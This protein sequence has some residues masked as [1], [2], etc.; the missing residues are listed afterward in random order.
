MTDTTIITRCYQ[1]PMKTMSDPIVGE[2][3]YPAILDEP[4]I[5]A[6]SFT[7]GSLKDGTEF[8]VV[9]STREGWLAFDAR[10]P[11]QDAQ[12]GDPYPRR[13]PSEYPDV[14]F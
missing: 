4:E 11:N 9:G 5:D 6:G 10:F 2:V 3:V 7:T 8:Y 1:S 13:R 12:T 14:V